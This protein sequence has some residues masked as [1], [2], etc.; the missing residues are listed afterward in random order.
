MKVNVPDSEICRQAIP[1]LRGY[2][3]QLYRSLE[4]WLSLDEYQ[5]L[6]L[7]VAEDFAVLTDK[8]V[9]AT[10][11][12]DTVRSGSVTLRTQ[13]IKAAIDSF[14]EISSSEPEQRCASHV[15]DH[16]DDRKRARI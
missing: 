15:F 16:V 8:V 2:A 12:K 10:Q 5:S 14:M 6:L 3:Y 1:A 11:V 13:A 4:A 7:E 9:Q